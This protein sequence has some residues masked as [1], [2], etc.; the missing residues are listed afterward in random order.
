MD[1]QEIR[2]K[3]EFRSLLK[4]RTWRPHSFGH[5]EKI[6]NQIVRTWRL[7]RDKNKQLPQNGLNAQAKRHSHI[8]QAKWQVQENPA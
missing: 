7:A 6:Q 1:P 2:A 3:I 4:D 5:K 8:L